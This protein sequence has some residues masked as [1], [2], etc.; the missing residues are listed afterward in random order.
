MDVVV[1]EVVGPH[2]HL[3]AAGVEVDLDADN[4]GTWALH[5]HN[6]YHMEMGMMTTLKYT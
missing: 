1:G 3:V 6:I 5:C 4:P 2:R